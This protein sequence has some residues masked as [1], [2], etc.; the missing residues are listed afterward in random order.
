MSKPR[1]VVSA[2]MPDG[3]FEKLAQRRP[4]SSGSTRARRPRSKALP[5]ANITY[6]LPPLARLSEAADLRWI[7]LISA[8]VPQ[9]LCPLAQ[10]REKSS[11]PTSRD[12]TAILSPNTP[13]P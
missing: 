7:Q 2:W 13:S 10:E 1:I 6:G 3:V 4:S 9:E 11:S 5:A 12:C 8:G